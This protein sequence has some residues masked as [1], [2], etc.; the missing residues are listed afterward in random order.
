MKTTKL[1][2]WV[3]LKRQLGS[4]MKRSVLIWGYLTPGFLFPMNVGG[5][6][7]EEIKQFKLKSQKV[8]FRKR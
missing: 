2:F 1:S 6:Q 5:F 8:S 4:K 3:I 7:C